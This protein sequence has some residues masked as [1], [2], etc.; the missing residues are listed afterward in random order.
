MKIL[1]QINFTSGL[2]ADRWIV[3]GY[4]DAFEEL[5]HE[6]FFLTFQDDLTQKIQGQE[7]ILSLNCIQKQL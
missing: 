3:T 7:Y 2:G 4:K 6:F 5:G 1:H